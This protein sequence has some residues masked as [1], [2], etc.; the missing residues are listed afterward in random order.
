MKL[1]RT[2]AAHKQLKKKGI[3]GMRTA[4]T[5]FAIIF[6]III[7]I[8]IMWLHCDVLLDLRSL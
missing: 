5:L 1:P 2:C 4:R 3:H 6:A 8:I 7:I